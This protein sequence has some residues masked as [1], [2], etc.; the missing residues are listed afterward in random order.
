M[1]RLPLEHVMS[2]GKIVGLYQ[3]TIARES[4]QARRDASGFGQDAGDVRFAE[5]VIGRSVSFRGESLSITGPFDQGDEPIPVLRRDAR[6]TEFS[7]GQKHLPRLF[8]I[9]RRIPLVNETDIG[10][11]GSS[12]H[13]RLDVP[14][15]MLVPSHDV[16]GDTFI[17]PCEM[18]RH[19]L[20][21]TG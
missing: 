19:L 5:K 4:E 11:L 15:T 12:P 13:L 2:L 17:Q 21:F 3:I 9:R 7:H 20:Q 10:V 16:D 6:A 18:V 1:Y 8:T 14:V